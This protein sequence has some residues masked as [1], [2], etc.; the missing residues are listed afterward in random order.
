MWATLM[1]VGYPCLADTHQIICG[2]SSASTAIG[3]L[4]LGVEKPFVV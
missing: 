1:G 2:R 4:I 3:E